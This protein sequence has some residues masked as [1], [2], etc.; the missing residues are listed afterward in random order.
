MFIFQYFSSSVFYLCDKYE[1]FAAVWNWFAFEYIVFGFGLCLCHFIILFDCIGMDS[2]N[3]ASLPRLAPSAQYSMIHYVM[4][5]LI[6]INWHQSEWSAS[7]QFQWKREKKT[8][9]KMCVISL[10][11]WINI[12][13]DFHSLF[14]S[15]NN[16]ISTQQ[17]STMKYARRTCH[18]YNLKE[19]TTI[20]DET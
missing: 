10:S 13:D 15:Q 3:M 17:L 5:F 18:N 8:N 2:Q 19:N 12:M 7:I 1:F 4:H 11:L 16:I 6:W 20:D 14:N 9:R